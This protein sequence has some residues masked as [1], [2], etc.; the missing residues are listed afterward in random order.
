MSET[1]VVTS[2]LLTNPLIKIGL[3]IALAIIMVGMGLSLTRQD[4][5]RVAEKPRA[6][7]IG[8]IG[9]MLLIPA[10]GF[11]LAWLFLDYFESPM[12]AVGIVLVSILPG[13]TTSNLLTYLARA[14]L[15]LSITLTVIASLVTLLTIP[16]LLNLALETFAA[17]DMNVHVSAID[18]IIMILALVII[19][20]FVGMLIKRY[21]PNFAVKMEKPVSIF[22][23]FVL[24][25]LVIAI[26]AVEWDKMPSWLEEATIPVLAL[27]VGSMLLALVIGTLGRLP[28][29]DR[30]TVIVELSIKNS[31]IGVTI[32][33]TMLGNMELGIASA[34]YGL[35]MYAS[36]LVLA[37]ISRSIVSKSKI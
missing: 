8:T 33:F 3:P 26:V 14:N 18:T 37:V 27:N 31:T 25:G 28:A 7:A 5:Q 17:D 1:E 36:A 35:L 19:P 15:A 22:S 4:F 32:A 6:V 12:M 16:F 30:V 20:V 13:G 29:R 9:Q 11:L 10:L 23:M 21:V 2:A 34:V 24:L